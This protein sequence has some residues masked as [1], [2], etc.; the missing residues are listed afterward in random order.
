MRN[1]TRKMVIVVVTL[2][3][4]VGPTWLLNRKPSQAATASLCIHPLPFYPDDEGSENRIA[5][6]GFYTKADVVA[7]DGDR[8]LNSALFHDLCNP[9][10]S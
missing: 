8:R 1:T 10:H 5:L 6:V 3:L 4:I 2:S 7:H 9:P